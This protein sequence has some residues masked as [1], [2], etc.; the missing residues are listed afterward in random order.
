MG[1]RKFV[2]DPLTL[3]TVRRNGPLEELDGLSKVQDDAIV[4]F[5]FGP[6]AVRKEFSER[7]AQRVFRQHTE[8]TFKV[9]ID[10][11]QASFF[12]LDHRDRGRVVHEDA[13]TLFG[14]FQLKFEV[15]A[16]GD[17]AQ[18]DEDAVDLRE[19][20]H[21]VEDALHPTILA[22][23]VQ[24]AVIGGNPIARIGQEYGMAQPCLMTFGGMQVTQ[25][26]PPHDRL[27]IVTQ[28]FS[29]T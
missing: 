26:I 7:H 6:V 27:R 24:D 1:H 13:E 15:L 16:V 10:E 12:I 22:V 14:F 21:V 23:R 3:Y 20:E 9:G 11:D 25:G 19:V 4:L 5:G 17:I 28:Q 29:R 18:L 8:G 2:H